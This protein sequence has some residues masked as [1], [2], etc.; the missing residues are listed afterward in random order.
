MALETTET[1]ISVEDAR[2]YATLF[3]LILPPADEVGDAELENLLRRAA[4]YMDRLYGLRF[5]GERVDPLQLL[6]FPRDLYEEAPVQV[7]YAQVELVALMYANDGKLPS[8]SPAI[9]KQTVKV[10]GLEE[11]IEYADAQGFG[12]NPYLDIER[13]LAPWFSAITVTGTT[14][15]PR[16]TMTRGE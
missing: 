2:D 11:S 1:Y 16:L 9:K 14:L 13:I 5:L 8:T 7:G 3:G 10:E 4:I 6:S 15:K 12:A